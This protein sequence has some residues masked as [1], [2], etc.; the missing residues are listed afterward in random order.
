RGERLRLALALYHV[1][2]GKPAAKLPDLV[3]RYLAEVPADPYD[4]R[5]FRYRI[6]SG[7]PVDERVLKNRKEAWVPRPVPVGQGV[8]WSV[9]PDGED[10][11][12]RK[13]G[14]SWRMDPRTW[15]GRG[16]DAVFIVPEWGR[17]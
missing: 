8:V 17:R 7:K 4:G 16:M 6:S 15:A 12:A 13:Q 10:D 9:G 3:P 14:L 11:G 2:E 1:E 5:P